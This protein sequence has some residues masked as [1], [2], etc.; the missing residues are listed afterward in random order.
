MKIVK[1]AQIDTVA[2]LKCP[3]DHSGSAFCFPIAHNKSHEGLKGITKENIER[4]KLVMGGREDE[5]QWYVPGRCL[6]PC[7]NL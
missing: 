2:C 7:P 1:D 4:L 6:T 5:P 3:E